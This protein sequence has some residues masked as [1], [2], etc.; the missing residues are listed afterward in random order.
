MY[1]TKLEVFYVQR[2][3]NFIQ[4]AEEGQVHFSNEPIKFNL[5]SLNT[6]RI[7]VSIV[8]MPFR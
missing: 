4:R 1:S 5:V 2:G 6:N 8:S 7:T 3:E